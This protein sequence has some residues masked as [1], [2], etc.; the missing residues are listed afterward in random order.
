MACG[1]FLQLPYNKPRRKVCPAAPGVHPGSTRYLITPGSDDV[2]SGT[3][4][5]SAFGIRPV[6]FGE[7]SPCPMICISYRHICINLYWWIPSSLKK[8]RSTRGKDEAASFGI[9]IAAPEWSPPLTTSIC[10]PAPE[11]GGGAQESEPGNVPPGGR[12]LAEINR[13]VLGFL[14]LKLG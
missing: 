2:F 8:T 14:D 10:H 11:L 5:R 4:L 7:P 6:P 9:L 1:P 3:S 12:G 13:E